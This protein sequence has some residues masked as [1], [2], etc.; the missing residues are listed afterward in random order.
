MWNHWVGGYVDGRLGKVMA[1]EGWVAGV[2]GWMW[3]LAGWWWGDVLGCGVRVKF[4]SGWFGCVHEF[5]GWGGMLLGER[6]IFLPYVRV[7][8]RRRR[9]GL[10]GW[11]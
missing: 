3:N 2:R 9:F 8:W 6:W 5:G 1:G 10:P 11:P 4:G 7:A